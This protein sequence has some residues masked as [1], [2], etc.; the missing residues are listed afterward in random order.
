MF[1]IP[2]IVYRG[3]V[4]SLT[5]VNHLRKNIGQLFLT[6]TFLSA[7]NDFPVACVFAQKDNL[8]K[9]ESVVFEFHVDTSTITN[10]P[11]ADIQNLSSNRSE[12]EFLFCIGTAFRMKSIEAKRIENNKYW[13]IVL[14]HAN[15]NNDLESA[16]KYGKLPYELGNES[17][18]IK[19]GLIA[20]R[21]SRTSYDFAKAERYFRLHLNEVFIANKNENIDYKSLIT[22]YHYLAK[23]CQKKG[24]YGASLEYNERIIDI[25]STSFFCDSK[26]DRI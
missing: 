16:N 10:R 5:E 2:I 14:E 18:F 1:G 11:Y 9:L 4:I 22:A 23:I 24:D 21:T 12:Q 15:E 25:C 26:H 20:L 19:L 3:Q 17:V 13:H 8:L 7:T 6:N